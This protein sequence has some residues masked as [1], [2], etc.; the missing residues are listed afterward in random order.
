[1]ETLNI[2]V[3]GLQ[4]MSHFWV[5]PGSTFGKDTEYSHRPCNGI[6]YSV[7]AKNIP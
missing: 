1:M 3:E 7:L 5:V 6:Y 2:A 4:L